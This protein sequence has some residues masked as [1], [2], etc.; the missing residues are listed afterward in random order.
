MLD[1][2]LYGDAV[3]FDSQPN[4]SFAIAKKLGLLDEKENAE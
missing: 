3:Y 2:C 1:L 4:G